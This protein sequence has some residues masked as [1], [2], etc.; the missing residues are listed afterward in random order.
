MSNTC[1]GIKDGGHFE[2]ENAMCRRILRVANALLDGVVLLC[3]LTVGAY[4]AYALW[5]NAQVYGAAQNVRAE[6]LQYKPAR[7]GDWGASFEK[8]LALNPDICGWISLD[9]TGIDYPILQGSTNL[10]YINRDVYGEFSLA[11]SIFLDTRNSRDFLDAYSLLYGHHMENGGMF[12]DLDRYRE[13]DFFETNRTGTLVTRESSH[14]LEIFA[15]LLVD[16]GEK[17]LFEP[18]RW[19]AGIEG[20]LSFAKDH[21]LCW[22]EAAPE[23]AEETRVLALSTCASDF[24]DARTV[25]LA[26]IV[27]EEEGAA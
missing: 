18:E 4:A 25:V 19:Q 23:Q 16:A 11:G 9:G 17:N 15:C 5:D 20:P 12:G 2:K 26:R 10:T 3:L 7:D 14:S 24:T 13:P 22:R 8:L 1:N 6:M 21:A 27:E